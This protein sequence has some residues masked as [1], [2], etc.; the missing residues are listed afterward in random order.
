[1]KH[2][3]RDIIATTREKLPPSMK[4]KWK[5]LGGFYAIVRWCEANLH[6]GGKE[7]DRAN[8]VPVEQV[9]RASAWHVFDMEKQMSSKIQTNGA[10]R[11]NL[12]ITAKGKRTFVSIQASDDGK[13]WGDLDTWEVKPSTSLAR[14]VECSG[15]DLLR[16]YAQDPAVVKFRFIR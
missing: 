15:Y 10:Q 3:V 9:S 1:M 2:D 13:E 14:R 4:S 7:V 8:P 16:F 12:L 5:W 11:I 6:I